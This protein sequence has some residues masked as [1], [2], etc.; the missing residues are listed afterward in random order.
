MHV[1]FT[2]TQK[3][4]TPAQYGTL[5]ELVAGWGSGLV[6]HHG[7][8][9]G[10]DAQAH[11]LVRALQPGA[12][13]HGHPPS[14]SS[15]RSWRIFDSIQHPRS[16]LARNRDIVD[17]CTLLVA[18]PAQPQEVLRSGTWAT[19][20]YARGWRHKRLI[21]IRPDGEMETRRERS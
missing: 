16:Y 18:T 19:V 4:M 1:G 17:A 11:E 3:G 6:F 15:K 12:R 13:I 9:V 10:A 7:D 8:C 21:V 5:S 14:N 20:R 2:G